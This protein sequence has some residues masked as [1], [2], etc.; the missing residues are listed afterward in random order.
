MKTSKRILVVEDNDQL[1]RMYETMFRTSIPD[2][3]VDSAENGREALTFLETHTCNLVITDLNMPGVSGRDLYLHLE[4]KCANS[5]E[6]LP[7]FIFCSGVQEALDVVTEFCDT[8]RNRML[9]KPF[10]T[11]DILQMATELLK[12]QTQESDDQS[13]A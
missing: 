4:E 2:V 7:P 9:L 3:I 11:T 10:S 13:T 5:A 8:S 12:N 1:R 6:T